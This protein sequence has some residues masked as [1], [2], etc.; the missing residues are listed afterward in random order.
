MTPSDPS[1]ERRDRMKQVLADSYPR[2]AKGNRE[3]LPDSVLSEIT[4]KRTAAEPA[5]AEGIIARLSALFRSPAALGLGAAAALVL[6]AVITFYP[7]D[8]NGPDQMRTTD[9]PSPDAA[10]VLLHDLT[11]SQLEEFRLFFQP[12][13]LVI[14]GPNETLDAVI[15]TLKERPRLIVVDG[16]TETISTP[17]AG[18]DAPPPITFSPGQGGLP[19][20]VL[21]L[22]GDLSADPLE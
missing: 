15:A 16:I 6:V 14:V 10:L 3:P 13:Q 12:N 18:P 2:V 20:I 21:D 19:T 5:R 9:L 17:F 8:K 1:P 4:G 11:E 22:D 7:T